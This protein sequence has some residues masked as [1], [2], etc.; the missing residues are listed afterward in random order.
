MED[1]FYWCEDWETEDTHA[2]VS[3]E[4]RTSNALLDSMNSVMGFL[5]FTKESPQDFEDK[6]LPTLDIKI[7]VDQLQ[8]W[9]MFYQ[10]PLCNNIVFQ[11]NV[12]SELH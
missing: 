5:N 9:Y 6:K 2:N 3:H 8:I 10:K 11:E 7:W 12:Q 1:G 4:E